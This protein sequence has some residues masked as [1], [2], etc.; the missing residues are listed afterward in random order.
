MHGFRVAWP[1]ARG[2]VPPLSV[3]LAA[4]LLLFADGVHAQDG[5]DATDER[6]DAIQDVAPPVAVAVSIE[7]NPPDSRAAY[8]IGETIAVTVTFDEPVTVDETHGSPSLALTIGDRERQAI[9]SNGSNTRDLVF[10]YRVQDGD[11]DADGVAVPADG[12]ALN[13]GAITDV[14]NN[15]A[16]LKN[17]AVPDQPGQRVDGERPTLVAS[18]AV[19]VAGGEVS[20]AFDETLDENS[21]PVIDAFSVVGQE[22]AY[23]VTSVSVQGDSVWLALSPAVPAAEIFVSVT[24]MEPVYAS[25]ESLR[26]TVGN[27]AASFVSDWYAESP[28]TADRTSR[29]DRQPRVVEKQAIGDIL[30]NKA[31]R[32]PAERKVSSRLLEARRQRGDPLKPQVDAEMRDE[33]VMVDIRSDVTPEVLARIRALGGNIVDRLPRYRSIRARLTPEAAV[34]LAEM[35]AVQTIRPAD[36]GRTRQEKDTGSALR[37]ATSK[38]NTSEGDTAHRA[39]S[40]RST[41]GVDGT[42]IGIGVLSTGVQTLAERQASGDLPGRV[43]VLPGQAGSGAEGTAVLE[44]V[45]D[46]APGAELY[47]ATGS[48]GQARFAA[49]IEALCDAGANVIVDDIGY[50]S[51]AVFQDDLVAQGVN[52]AVADGCYFFSAAGNEGNL[53]DGTSGV[54]EGDYDAGTAL[55]LNGENVG[56]RHEFES[57]VEENT[58][59]SRS[60]R[61][62]GYWVGDIVLQWADPWGA[63]GNDYDLFLVDAAGNVI[64]S[65]TDTQDGSQDPIESIDTLIFRNDDFRLVVVKASGSDRYL[66]LQVFDGQLE[67]ATAGN[68]YGHAAAEKAFGIGQ[69]NVRTAGGTGGIFNGTESVLRSSSDGP[70]R[71][72]FEPDGTAITAGNFTST[73]G[74]LLNKPDLAAASCV[75][76]ATPGFSRFC[77]TS[78][79]APHAAAIAALVLEGAGGPGNVT[80]AQ[81]RTAMASM[82]LDI[83]ATGADRDSGAG[84]AMAPPAV[85]ALDVAQANRNRAPT[86]AKAE[87]DRTLTPGSDAIEIDLTAVFSDPDMDTLTYV[88]VSSDP[89]RLTVEVSASTLTLTPGSPGRVVVNVRAVDED[90]LSVVVSFTVTVSAGTEDYDSDNDG[91]IDVSNVAQLDAMR[92][93]LNADGIVD[94]AIWRAYYDAFPSGALEMGCPTDGCTGYELNANLDF[95]TDSSGKIDT[96]DTY[97]NGGA[98]WDPIGDED[99]PFYATFEGNGFSI[100]KLFIER[101]TEDGVGLFG[102]IHEFC[103]IHRV[104]LTNVQVTGQDRVG[105]LVGSGFYAW[106]AR[107]GAA[108][109]VTGEDEVGGLVGRAWGRSVRYSYAAVNVSGMNAVGGLV[110]HHIR[111]RIEASYATGNVSGQDSVGGL[112]GASSDTRW[113]IRASYATGNVSGGGTRLPDRQSVYNANCGFGPFEYLPYS[114]G[115]GGLAGGTCAT[116]ESSYAIGAVSGDEAV[117]GLIGTELAVGAIA[118][119]WDLDRSGTRVGVGSNDSN[120]NGVHDGTELRAIGVGGQTTSELQSPTDYAGIYQRWTVDDL[121]DFGTSAQYP[122]LSVDHD[123]NSRATWEEFGYQVRTAPTLAASTSNGQ[124]QVDLTWTAPGTS[125]WFPAPSVSYTLYRKVGTTVEAVATGLSVRTYSDMGVTLDSRTTYWVAVVIDGG[126]FVRSTRVS[127]TAGTDNQPPIAEAVLADLE[128]EVGGSAATVDVSGA[129][130]DPDNDTLTFSAN[131]SVTG[132]ATVETSGSMVTVTPQSAGQTV[133]TVTAT[134]A[135]GPNSSAFQ[136]FSVT[137]GYDYDSDGDRLIEF[138]SLAQLDAMRHDLDGNGSSG[139]DEHGSAFPAPFARMGCGFDGCLGYELEEDLDFDTDGSGMADSGDTYWNE[140]VGWNPIGSPTGIVLGSRVGAFGGTLDGN[141]H[142]LANLF[143]DR[144]D[145]AGLF[146]ALRGPAVVRNLKLTGVDVTGK[147]FVG[148]LAGYNSHATI[149]GSE[150][151]GEVSGEERVGGLVG[152]NLGVI[153]GSRSSA[154]VT[155]M[156]PPCEQGPCV[157]SYLIRPGTGGLAGNNEGVVRSSYARGP[158]TG[159]NQ[160]GGLTGD[161]LGT[162]GGSYATGTV[163]G[164]SRVGG[165]V[166]KNGDPI[167]R[168]KVNAS[169]AAGRVAGS[170]QVGGL[171][172]SNQRSGT[173]SA[174]YATGRV[175]GGGNDTSAGLI[176][177]TTS[178]STGTVTNSYWDTQTS[179]HTTGSGGRTTS[180]LQSPTGY[181]GNFQRWNVDLDGDGTNDAPWHFG[182]SGD[183]PALQAD[184]DGG[185]T[186]SWEEFGYQLRDGPTLSVSTNAEQPVLTWTA[187]D[188]RDWAP[189]PTVLYTVIRDDG[190]DLE[191]I[192]SGLETL[193]YTDSTA[194]EGETYNYQVAAGVDVGEAVRSSIVEVTVPVRDTTPPSVKSIESD[195]THPTND[196]FEVTITFLKSVTGLSESEIEVTNG[197]GSDFAGSGATRTLTVTP[198]ADFDGD[199]TVTIPAGVAEDS[200]MNPNEAGSATFA[201]DT[202]APALA[203]TNGATVNGTILTLAFDET[204]EFAIIAEPAFTVT[205]GAPTRSISGVFITRATAILFLSPPVLYGETGIEVDYAPPSRDPAD[206]VGNQIVD[207]AGNQAA[208]ITDRSVTNNTPATTLST[209][210]RLTMNEAQVAE[211]GPAKTVT[212]T[213]VLNRAARPSATTVTIEVGAGTDT[214]TEGSDYTTVGALTLTIPAYATSG[215]V[216]FTLTPTNDRIDEP[217]ESLTVSGST[218]VAGLSVTPPGGLALD[219]ADNDAAPS[220]VLSVS[221]STIDEDGGTATATVG[222]GSGS[223]FATDQTVRLAVAGTA[224]ETADYTISGTTL[225]LPAGVG[226]SA[227]MVS[228]TV[229]GVDDSL[230]DDDEAIEI[231]GSRNGVAFGSR[232]T[233]AIVDDDWPELTVTFRQ[234]DYRIAEGGRV[235][236]P[237]TL[238]AVPER[239]VT[240]PIEFE[241]LAGAEAID[242]SVSPASLTFGA[243]ETDKTLRVSASNDSV[244]DPGES[245][246][247]SFGTSL[248]ERIS[249]GG[250]AQTAVAIRDTDF[251][252]APAFAAGSGTTEAETDVYVVNEVEGA[253]RL[254]L[255]LQTP[256]GARVVDVVDP[257]V[258]T[259]AT[260]ENA[261][262]KGMDEDYATRRRSG[263][264]GDYGEF[265]RDLSFA[266]GDFSDDGTCDCARAEKA[267]SVD[268]FDDRV[269]ERV[270]VFGLRLSRKSGRLGVA[271]KDITAKIAED[272]AEPVLT[273]EAIPGSIAEAG[274]ASTVT[275]STGSGSTFPAPQTIRLDLSGTAT[276]GTDYTI[277]A[278]ALTLPAGVG[279]DPSSVTTTVRAKD[280]SI[281]DDSETIVVSATRGGVEFANRTVTVTDDEV[282][283]TRVDLAVNPAQVREDVGATTVRVTASLNADARGQD[284]EVTVT[285]GAS[286]D[287]AIEGT[288]YAMVPDLTLTIDAG[289]TT[290]DATFSVDPTNNDSVDG[291]KTITVDGSTSGLAV[292]SA[293]LTLNDDD[294]AST[295]VT[296]TLDPREVSERA[297]SRTVRV[298][299]TLD[300]GTRTTETV[301]TVTVG[302]GADSALEGTDYADVPELELTIAANRTDG[303]VTFTLR[304][305]NDRTAEGTETISVSGDVAGLTVVSAELALADD[306]MASTRLDL[307]LNP[308]T[309]SEG[310]V[311]TDVVVTGSLDAG[312]RTS[313]SVVTVTVGAATDS[314]TEGLDYANVSTLQITVPA[315]ETTGQAMFTLSPENDA[316]AE[317]AETISVT[318][319]VSGLT[320]EPATLT[321]SDNDTA[322]RVVTLSVDPDSVSEDTPE[323]VTVTASLNAGARAEV[324]EVR[325]TVGAAADTAVPGTDYERVSERT[326]TILAGETSGTA[327]FRLEPV[328]NDSSDGARTLSVTGSTTVAELRIEPA[329]G[330]KVALEDDDNPAVRVV[331]EV[332]TVVEAASEVYTVELQ[333]RPTADVTVTIG[334]VSGDLSLDK[335]SLVFTQADWQDPQPV[336]VTAAD[337]DDSRQDPDVTL[338]HRA[339]GAAEYRRLR[340][341]L[342]VSIRE[343]DPSLVFSGSALDVRE[344]QTATYTV[345]LATVPTADVTVQV[346]GVSGDVSLDK[347]RLVFGPGDWE[348][349]QTII[350]E[351]AEDDD[352]S[353]DP[354]VTLTHQAS[355]GGYDGISGT[356]RVTIRENDGGGTTGGGSG[357][358]S[359]GGGGG[360][361]NRPPVVTDP[362][363]AQVLELEGSVRIDAAE[364][365]RDPDNRTMTFEAESADVSVATVEVDG[366][367]V[368]VE[369]VAHGVTTVTVTAVDH[370]RLRVSQSFE[371]S[372]GYQVS[373]GSAQVSAPEGGTP[374]LRVVLNRPRDVATT[375]RYVLG[376]DGD[377]A[378]PDA[379][380]A[381]HDGMDGEVT[382]APGATEADIGIAIRDDTDI[383]PPRESFTVT[384]QAT[385]AQL[386]DFGLGIATVRVTVQEGVCDR[387]RQVRNALRRSLPCAAVSGTD[388]AVRT[389]LDLTNRDMGA[390]QADDLSGLSGLTVLDLS[391]NALTSLPE[392]MFDGLGSLGEV[393][394]QDN[395]GAPFTLQME[396]VR[397]DRALSSPGPARVVAR[398]REGAPFAMRAALSAV[399]GTLTPATALV[400]V[401]M[402][403]GAPIAVTQDAA[404]ATRVTA[405]APAIPDTR[406]GVLGT[407]PCYQGITTTAGGPLVLFKAPPEVTDTPSRTALA[408]DGDAARID[409]SALFAASD[410]G[411]LTY[412]AGSSDPGL[413]SAT[414][415]GDTLTLASNED[416]REGTVT[417]TVTATDDDGLTVTLT[418]AVTVESMP[419]GLLRG[420]RRVLLEQAMERRGTEVE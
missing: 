291:A 405:A 98:G 28:E 376:V 418:F 22:A 271:G 228:A 379:D 414:V 297:G 120:D 110:G 222:T 298:T 410:G 148:G 44:I 354:A 169:Y 186:A 313:A 199:I 318:G 53:N 223:T 357:G 204:L 47:F 64:E 24:Y 203:T 311:P 363:E 220:L 352:S 151:A 348:D 398:V 344:G 192:A 358:G 62:G 201:A 256:R 46:L 411:A 175:S 388:L 75:T 114:G 135:G 130:R 397:R 206:V 138:D 63:S 226:T 250:I 34:A 402:T 193:T 364:H 375:V 70:R 94:G 49:N 221:A 243:T 292:R 407:Y 420:W 324:T 304:P 20:I 184:L 236:L 191:A 99:A 29:E 200:S 233:I 81:L 54:W 368:T 84:I 145:Y 79:A 205:G 408:A 374:M 381:D 103:V 133:V 337:D 310:A 36:E 224:T 198:D 245:V 71:I 15:P 305:T 351:A 235:D 339:S 147:E 373:F 76:T 353:T 96:G 43:T 370:R 237:V 219:I 299:G 11:A 212:V 385:E 86:V 285:V 32:T 342:V 167:F 187:V 176:G 404:G 257:V 293:E 332:L 158:V 57:G 329:T 241:N 244:V 9:Y 278:T 190:T 140:G 160:V 286:G 168:G 105:S 51:E 294:V 159:D 301:V 202:L 325:L 52:A 122:A 56:V 124:A 345:A 117:G 165:L 340:T 343:N 125:S 225:T 262:S 128:F 30:T 80:Q 283:S 249:E 303:T 83:E 365:F 252:F 4:L 38:V 406:C 267:V 118:S 41:Y 171:V 290:A 258:V 106:V 239:R 37:A 394:L 181:S 88:A 215:T 327:A 82:A 207:V 287:S 55:T 31:L 389:E 123:D 210:V 246:A 277:D 227:S 309:V 367:I 263:T 259:L 111:N 288:D 320:V 23:S 242:Y 162:I 346:T 93:D 60:F 312:A 73:G 92:Y 209:A 152:A 25:A 100:D 154:V 50:L 282:G 328:D 230:D 382:I 272:D 27:A 270:E 335:T 131:P 231:T 67:I 174:S 416:G 214:A 48:S 166:G 319:Q 347:T 400:P 156:R 409:L 74:K 238:S 281:D 390:L 253:L 150:T 211:A 95:D 89:D 248:P 121:W 393:Q 195:A 333:T 415:D 413:A 359:G 115:V 8:R 2:F 208:P 412:F 289:E 178:Y 336:E 266:P 315:N 308:S 338:T 42:G 26:D 153:S 189:E 170:S 146:G 361:A 127:V 113:G 183:Y 45:H 101:N 341:D 360:S 14:A 317:G 275:V 232:Q 39:D 274:G 163:T 149:V 197:A 261:G 173:V 141:G 264:F 334:G 18:R 182:G 69:V 378:T 78:A 129:F 136:R 102:H 216:S 323:N 217:G 91:L 314:A 12:L 356:V 392:G 196:P 240:I 161:N 268:I 119:Y 218:T 59:A 143:V 68:T 77:G 33:R 295:Q 108:G 179:G 302:S 142:T 326:L 387:T 331:P 188:A 269:R 61:L 10:L 126:E 109:R 72:F 247:L 300:G 134:D 132:V 66:R 280:D 112:A 399:N 265:D 362:I 366:S 180:A 65:S 137:V 276:Q 40:A 377:P 306:D 164:E 350:V 213:G 391:G 194:S 316:I 155:G 5:T 107:S 307:S 355:G 321:L 371:V 322:S 255:S 3:V 384:L 7:S 254:S 369:G 349:A 403:A 417:I 1:P 284:T 35:D 260:R 85:N 234:A 17:P 273:L 296:L 251:T 279:Q 229:T 104:R 396:L 21:I 177:T 87:H 139:A 157:Y 144:E 90:G 185:G 401:G 97:W 19:S 330:A 13:D 172:G 395:P 16:G 372:V 116:I 383:E 419:R 386:Q 6:A 58:L 380:A